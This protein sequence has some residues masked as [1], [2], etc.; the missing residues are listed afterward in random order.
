MAEIVVGDVIA[1]L[2]LDASGFDQALTQ[3]QQRLTQL[4]QTMGQVRQQQT[5]SQQA[6]QQQAQAF[7]QLTQTIQQQTQATQQQTQGLQQHAQAFQQ[8]A[9]A[10]QQAAQATQ[11]LS[12][13]QAQLTSQVQQATT[14]AQA[15][16]SAW[17]TALSVAGGIGVATSIGA[18]VS[19]MKEL[20]TSIVTVGVQLQQLR[21]QFTAIQGVNSGAAAFQQMIGLAQRLGIELAP[22][23]EGFRRFDAATRGTAIQGEQAARI[24]EN[25]VVGMRAMGASSQQT[26]RGLLALQQMVSKGVVSQEELRQQLAEALPGAVQIAARAFG[27]TTQEL[28]KMLEKGQDSI[29]FVRRLS[30]QMRTELGGTVATATNTAAAAFQRLAN[31]VKLAGETIAASGLLDML[32]SMAETAT[33]LLTTVRKVQDERTREAGP[34]VGALPQGGVGLPAAIRER[35]AELERL[36]A[37]ITG[38]QAG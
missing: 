17:R 1:R 29:E 28:N 2:R 37:Q 4:S 18:I 22:L 21:Q 32:R 5:G 20:A 38:A 7:Q 6:T 36:Q 16:G 33:T 13:Q 3:A 35:Q 8:Q 30:D 31:E 34:P 27:V 24:F 12:Q 11:Q 14:A 25:I 9:Q 19:Q 15:S 23:A 26:E 10:L